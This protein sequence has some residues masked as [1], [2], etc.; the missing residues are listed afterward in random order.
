MQQ[1]RFS[2]TGLFF[3]VAFCALLLALFVPLF[4]Q[5]A[6]DAAG[7][8]TVQGLAFSADGSTVA[9]LFED[10]SV[11]IWRVSDQTLTAALRTGASDFRSRIAL[12]ADG[13]FAAVSGDDANRR[14]LEIWD[15]A[16]RK[17]L[18]AHPASRETR[19]AFSPKGT[20]LAVRSSGAPVIFYDCS[21]GAAPRAHTLDHTDPG[22]KMPSI[23]CLAMAF[24]DDGKTLATATANGVDFWELHTGQRRTSLANP[25]FGMVDEMTLSADAKKLAS[26]VSEVRQGGIES[27]LRIWDVQRAREMRELSH[28][29][30]LSLVAFQSANTLAFLPDGRTLVVAS[31]LLHAWDVET[32]QRRTLPL[33]A[34]ISAEMLAAPR[35]GSCFA[36]SDGQKIVLWDA[37]TLAPSQML[38]QPASE[39]PSPLWPV[40]ATGLLV[41]WG[42]H[43]AKKWMRTCST[44]GQKF[45]PARGGDAHAE[46]PAC[47]LK[48]LSGDERTKEQK[49]QAKENRKGLF[50][51]AAIILVGVALFAGEL[52]QHLGVSSWLL[53]YLLTTSLIAFAAPGA[54]IACFLALF[55]LKRR[56]LLH[57]K[58]LVPLVERVTGSPGEMLRRGALMVWCAE[59]TTMGGEF[60]GQLEATCERLRALTGRT[61]SLGPWL[62]CFVLGDRD[63]FEQAL[64]GVGFVLDKRFDFDAFYLPAPWRVGLL[65]EGELR[66]KAADPSTSVRSMLCYHLLE[67][68]G[69]RWRT[70]W[71]Y[72]GVAGVVAHWE[73]AEALARLNRHML[74]ALAAGHALDARAFFATAPLVPFR[75]RR[76]FQAELAVVAKTTASLAQYW[77][78]ME[79]LCGANAPAVR[80]LAFQDFLQDP[81]RQR[82]QERSLAEHFGRSPH[83]LL[84]DWRQWVQD[85]GVGNHAPP[86]RARAQWLLCGPVATL[87]NQQATSAER[88]Q[89]IRQLGQEGFVVGAEA[90]I[91]VVRHGPANLAEEAIWALETISGQS[92]GGDADQWDN[93]RSSLPASATLVDASWPS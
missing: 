76:S 65:N 89:A 51:L 32:G 73:D 9:A 83:E 61:P 35:R 2:L 49:R 17:M 68:L 34:D 60:E 56:R 43:Y 4:R 1:R 6:S 52:Q 26:R 70:S 36:V 62:R 33:D 18:A 92:L 21:S 55:Y 88:L 64:K 82:R 41:A 12:S 3:L 78:V 46:C 10:G 25:A 75:F 11:R 5:A 93:W 86:P 13:M 15:V 28:S 16:A 50:W 66:W 7:A 77:S 27:F 38:W 48:A 80:R 58:N 37:K 40:A 84:A 47:R 72:S 71:L 29:E 42:L 24:S 19:I 44:C 63:Q 67:S 53:A 69:V 74:S 22:D 57:E 23:V 30:D 45:T 14:G 79:Y 39:G 85:R 54:L 8:N 59:G 31:S 90:L 91:D 87:C 81:R 20:T